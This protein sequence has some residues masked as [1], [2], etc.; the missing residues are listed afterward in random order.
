MNMNGKTYSI[1]GAGRIKLGAR[2]IATVSSVE[3]FKKFQEENNSYSWNESSVAK[4]MSF[5]NREAETDAFYEANPLMVRKYEVELRQV[6]KVKM[7][8]Y[9][10]MLADRTSLTDAIEMN[11]FDC[12]L[13]KEQTADYN[14]AQCLFDE[15]E[16]Y[17][18]SNSNTALWSGELLDA[19]ANPQS[20]AG[21]VH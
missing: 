21:V 14:M 11:N 1:D 6:L 16:K 9:A 20:V 18:R 4:W 2:V 15:L 3:E 17:A 8:C 13:T 7:A 10:E 12:S 19:L 5:K